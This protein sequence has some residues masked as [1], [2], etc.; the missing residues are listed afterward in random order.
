MKLLQI[1][2]AIAVR[3]GDA[4]KLTVGIG[5]ELENPEQAMVIFKKE[6]VD[7]DVMERRRQYQSK[8][9]AE[10]YIRSIC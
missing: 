6:G 10:E 3:K 4:R 8:K 5:S 1:R 2:K 9:E 7:L